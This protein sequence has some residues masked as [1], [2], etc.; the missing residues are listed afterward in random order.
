[1][2]KREWG[3]PAVTGP[4]GKCPEDILGKDI[5]GYAQAHASARVSV[6][7][8]SEHGCQAP[9]VRTPHTWAQVGG[10]EKREGAA[11][12][13]VAGGLL[14]ESSGDQMP[15]LQLGSQS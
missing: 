6:L 3:D 12:R 15:A 9:Y 8:Q 10:P 1:M 14:M 2:F 4:S 5:K 7:C 11:A 13:G